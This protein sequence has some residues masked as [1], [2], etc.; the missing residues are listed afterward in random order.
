MRLVL[1]VFKVSRV[2]AVPKALRDKRAHQVPM[3][4]KAQ[5]VLLVQP[6]LLVIVANLELT[7]LTD[8]PEN[9]ANLVHAAT[10]VELELTV[11]QVVPVD[12]DPWAT[13]GGWVPQ[14][15]LDRRV[16]GVP[17]DPQDL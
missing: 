12:L 5:L 14:A 2:N 13:R 17:K 16:N 6:G 3:V 7:D 10:P 15:I 4:H 11:F 8:S 9:L 1:R